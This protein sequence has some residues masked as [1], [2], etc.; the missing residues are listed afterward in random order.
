MPSGEDLSLTACLASRS[1]CDLNPLT[2]N[3]VTGF[4]GESG[5]LMKKWYDFVKQL[6][7]TFYLKGMVGGFIEVSVLMD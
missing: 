7:Q 2:V 6:A 4:A 1:R 3:F 5:S